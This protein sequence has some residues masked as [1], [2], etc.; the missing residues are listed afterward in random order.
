MSRCYTPGTVH[1]STVHPGTIHPTSIDTVHPTSI[2]TVHLTSIDII[3]P[4]SIDTVHP[5]TVHRGAVHRNTIHAVTVHYGTVHRDTV[6]QVTVHPVSKNTVYQAIEGHQRDSI[7]DN[8]LGEILE[9]E[10]REEYAFLVESSK[11]VGSSY[12]CRPTPT[13]K[14]RS[15]SSPERRLTPLD[16]HQSTPLFGSDKTV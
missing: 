2:D 15:T 11:S 5:V 14:H 4:A 6:H 7:L 3:H 16:K 13:S 12:W 8:E 1:R 9:Q 10:K